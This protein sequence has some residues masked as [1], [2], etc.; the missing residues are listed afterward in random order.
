M[1]KLKTIGALAGS[2]AAIAGV[3]NFVSTE[4]KYRKY[5]E[6]AEKYPDGIEV[7][8]L[9]AKATRVKVRLVYHRGGEFYTYNQ[10][11]Y[12]GDG[13]IVP[14]DYEERHGITRPG[15]TVE[16]RD[17]ESATW[18][19]AEGTFVDDLRGCFGDGL[20]ATLGAIGFFAFRC[21]KEENESSDEESES[22][23]K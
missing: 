21:K 19:P 4:F 8:S 23:K 6:A 14:M 17:S 15:S 12:P 10:P 9:I 13:T 22:P 16:I 18:R 11:I 7:P 20:I 1:N 2:A 5:Y 3:A